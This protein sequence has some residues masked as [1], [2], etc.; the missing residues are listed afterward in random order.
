MA[1]HVST[2]FSKVF[3]L[4]FLC[5]PI[6]NLDTQMGKAYTDLRKWMGRSEGGIEE[7]R[8]QE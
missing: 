8:A 3:A 2:L 4:E 7:E 6:W 1:E 5:H